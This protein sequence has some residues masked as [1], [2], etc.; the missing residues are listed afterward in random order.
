MADEAKLWTEENLTTLIEKIR[1]RAL[2]EQQKDFFNSINGNFKISKQQIA[3]VKKEIKELRQSIEHI[4]NVLED[5][6]ARVEE[7]LGRIESHVWLSTRSSF[8]ER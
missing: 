5:K 3:E 6:V 8:Y 1:R 2:D 4:E 7:N